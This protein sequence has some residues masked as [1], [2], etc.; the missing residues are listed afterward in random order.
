MEV[1]GARF[2]AIPGDFPGWNIVRYYFDHWTTSTADGTS[3]FGQALKKAG[4]T[5]AYR[6]WARRK[7]EL[8]HRRRAKREEHGHG[9]GQRGN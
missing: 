9:A 8:L 5:R 2:R 6:E 4:Q 7:D 3:L 1:P